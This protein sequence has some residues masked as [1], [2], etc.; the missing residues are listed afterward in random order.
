MLHDFIVFH[1]Y[2]LKI[3]SNHTMIRVIKPEFLL[4]NNHTF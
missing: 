1:F 4:I 3:Y 2:Q